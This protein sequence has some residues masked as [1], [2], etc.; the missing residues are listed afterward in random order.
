VWAAP[1]RVNLLGEH[2]DYNDGFVLPV[3][4]DREVL[5]AVAPRDD[6][7]LRCRSTDLPGEADL[8]VAE[9]GPGRVQGWTAYVTGV[10]WAL[11]EA[12]VPVPGLDV[13][14]SSD[15]PVG[16]G[17]SSSAAL[18]ASVALAVADLAGADLSRLDL[19]VA[20]RRAETDVVGA[21]VGIMDQVAALLGRA[22]CALLLDCRSLQVTPVPLHLSAAGLRLL[23]I[24]TRVAHAHAGGEYA[25]RRR[26]CEAA[27]A[28]LGVP[29]LRDASLE[30]VQQRLT[31]DLQRCARHVVTENARVLAAA[32]L[33]A[34]EPAGQRDLGGLGALFAASH[35]SMRDDFRISCPELDLAVE[36]AVR[37]GAVAARMTGGGFGGC[38]VALVP[39]AV[40]ASLAAAVSD[41]F[42]AAGFRG[43]AVFE[44]EPSDGA[45]R[46]G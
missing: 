40:A 31:G 10:V 18:E 17:L 9:L 22:G 45:R 38:A 2:T 37:A 46:V 3:A 20:A 21:P 4:L 41:A 8:P 6:G 25:T 30:Q 27:A 7:R 11:R 16:A 14:I 12:G 36:S 35:A 39:D 26:A 32:D 43:P 28:E 42:A 23:V 33:L 19:A 29:A 24:D 5:A 34:G 13:L 1:G 44:V 15:V